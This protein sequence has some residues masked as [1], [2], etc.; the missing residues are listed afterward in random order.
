M[1]RALSMSVADPDGVQG[2]CFSPPSLPPFFI[3]ISYE[4]ERFGRN[5]TKLFQFH[6]IFKKN[7]I[8]AN[9]HPFI[10][11]NPLSRNPGVA[12]ACRS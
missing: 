1:V 7:E 12:P 4:S 3:E 9:P 2:V 10:H 6:G 8:K 5:E 11:M